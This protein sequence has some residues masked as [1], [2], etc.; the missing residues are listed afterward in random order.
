MYFI[1]PQK[2]CGECVALN[3]RISRALVA[4]E[5]LLQV[6]CSWICVCR[7]RKYS[8]ITLNSNPRENNMLF[9]SWNDSKCILNV[10]FP[11]C[12]CMS[13][14]GAVLLLCFRLSTFILHNVTFLKLSHRVH[15]GA[16]WNNIFYKRRR[17]SERGMPQICTRRY[18]TALKSGVK[19]STEWYDLASFVSFVFH[20]FFSFFLSCLFFLFPHLPS[21]SVPADSPAV[22]SR[23]IPQ[24]VSPL[25]RGPDLKGSLKDESLYTVPDFVK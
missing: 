16:Q 6:F 22:C 3:V 5:H 18:D 23:H 19:M 1:N 24:S 12:K 20:C 21:F 9:K 25:I 17:T 4:T 2:S 8:W 13:F 10:F 7:T 15:R 14:N 11:V